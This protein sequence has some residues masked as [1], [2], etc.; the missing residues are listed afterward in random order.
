MSKD[1]IRSIPTTQ[2]KL[3]GDV[4]A[5]KRHLPALLEYMEIRAQIQRAHFLALIKQG[6]KA[7]EAMYIVA[8]GK[9][10]DEAE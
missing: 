5:M 2:D 10:D 8:H 6:F 7:E 4:E 9:L 1:K 3:A